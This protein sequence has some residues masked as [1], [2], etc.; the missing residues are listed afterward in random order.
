MRKF[1]KIEN[2]EID[3]ETIKRELDLEDFELS[4]YTFK[5]LYHLD[6]NRKRLLE[7]NYFSF[8]WYKYIDDDVIKEIA[9]ELHSKGYNNIEIVN[10]SYGDYQLMQLGYPVDVFKVARKCDLIIRRNDLTFEKLKTS[11]YEELLAFEGMG[12]T[13]IRELVRGL[14]AANIEHTIVLPPSTE[15]NRLAK[16]K[17]KEEASNALLELIIT[18]S[19]LDIKNPI[20]KQI[21][22]DYKSYINSLT[23]KKIEEKLERFKS[24]ISKPRQ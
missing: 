5:V 9:E 24:K 12:D 15:E 20:D 21:Y 4:E 6:F 16:Q 11:S 17:A 1:K 7:A 18:Y 13:K 10:M 22:N 23:L 19:N 14:E 2:I 3:I 8:K